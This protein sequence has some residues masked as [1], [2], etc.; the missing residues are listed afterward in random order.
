MDPVV[1][2]ALARCD[3][4]LKCVPPDTAE[5]V[6]LKEIYDELVKDAEKAASEGG[7]AFIEPVLDRIHEFSNILLTYYTVREDEDEQKL[8]YWLDYEIAKDKAWLC[9]LNGITVGPE[10]FPILNQPEP[11]KPSVFE[12]HQ[13]TE[14]SV[15]LAVVESSD[16]RYNMY[17]I[18]GVITLV[19]LLSVWFLVK[20]FKKRKSHAPP[21]YPYNDPPPAYQ[22]AAFVSPIILVNDKKI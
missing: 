4:I 10:A 11:P 14:P 19:V 22:P 3:E 16:N 5:T 6:S 17:L 8:H 20:R 2:T 1:T 21:G 7:L 12:V 18:G 9:T 13:Q 15:P